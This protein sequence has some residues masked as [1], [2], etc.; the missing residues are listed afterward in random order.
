MPI[1]T[2]LDLGAEMTL[3]MHALMEDSITGAAD[4]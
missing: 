3:L 2:C 1:V 4:L